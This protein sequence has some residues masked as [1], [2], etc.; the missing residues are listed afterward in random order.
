ML[1]FCLGATIFMVLELLPVFGK[2]GRRDPNKQTVTIVLF[3]L[4]I[5]MA[6]AALR[7]VFRRWRRASS[8]PVLVAE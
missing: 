5:I 1:L 4:C 3:V 8:I 7:T 2:E 6:L